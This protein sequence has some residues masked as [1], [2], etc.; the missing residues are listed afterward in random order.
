MFKLY[1]SKSTE[2][3]VDS[4]LNANEKC[5]LYNTKK[6]E[7]YYIHTY[8]QSKLV[9]YLDNLRSENN[10]KMFP[11]LRNTFDTNIYH[12]CCNC[13]S[14]TLYCDHLGMGTIYHY[15]VSIK[16]TIDNVLKN[17]PNW[18]VR[19][20]MN[21]SVYDLIDDFIGSKG[22]NIE[23]IATQ[24]KEIFD[25]IHKAENVEIHTYKCQ[26]IIEG[27][28][29]IDRT[30][31]FRF[32]PLFQKDVNLCVVREA[33]GIV[34]NLDCHN[35]KVFEKSNKLMYLVPY[36]LY[37]NHTY[38][39]NEFFENDIKPLNSYS[40]WLQYYKKNM[41]AEYFKNKNNLYDILAGTF[42]IKLKINK[43]TY[44][45]YFSKLTF[46]IGDTKEN[47]LN[48]GLDEILLLDMLKDYISVSY[49]TNENNEIQYNQ[50]QYDIIYDLITGVDIKSISFKNLNLKESLNKLVS[51]RLI[52]INDQCIDNIVKEYGLLEDKI[53]RDK[54]DNK[55]FMITY[56]IDSLLTNEFIIYDK[57][58][59]IYID[60]FKSYLTLL[61][62]VYTSKFNG[63]VDNIDLIPVN[64]NRLKKYDYIY[65]NFVRKVIS[66]DI[67]ENIINI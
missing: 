35:I 13:I 10:E 53:S 58:F 9:N 44:D 66:F 33:D 2:S 34:T 11:N 51:E 47:Y 16:R 29:K 49:T 36:S 65:D 42:T 59:N 64:N 3:I 45:S 38:Y 67:N 25:Y 62:K 57:A 30:R 60:K 27:K 21:L 15:L 63:R 54:Y 56:F 12:N 48:S 40:R 41:E 37:Y 7:K 17:L 1:H 28:V 22:Q 4:P 23:F 55:E 24:I 6:K 61:N 39:T 43:Q 46:L 5:I 18:I 20:Y 31:T 19:I 52:K 8:D 50:Y 26:E 14:I 32:M